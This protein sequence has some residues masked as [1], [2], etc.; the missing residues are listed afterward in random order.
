MKA[1]NV[2]LVVCVS[3]SE[4]WTATDVA[5]SLEKYIQDWTRNVELQAGASVE[6]VSIESVDEVPAP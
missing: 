6:A 2:Q 4:R 1:C 3:H 5:E